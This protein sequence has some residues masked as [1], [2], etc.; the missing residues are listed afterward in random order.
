MFI[1]TSMRIVKAVPFTQC[2][3][4]PVRHDNTVCPFPWNE[5]YGVLPAVILLSRH[6]QNTCSLEMYY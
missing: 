6:T 2:S 3:V 1:V 5:R 4:R